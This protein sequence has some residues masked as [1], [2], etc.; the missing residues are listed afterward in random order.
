MNIIYTEINKEW[1]VYRTAKL[2]KQRKAK[3]KALWL[4]DGVE[5]EMSDILLMS[6][7]YF[8]NLAKRSDEFDDKINLS[9]FLFQQPDLDKCVD[10]SFPCLCWSSFYKNPEDLSIRAKRKK[11]LKAACYPK[12]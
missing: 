4:V 6:N 2:K 12:S 7:L 11:V 3:L 9:A 8:I 5:D 10:E 1:I